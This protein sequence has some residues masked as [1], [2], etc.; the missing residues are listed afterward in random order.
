M[1]II[2]LTEQEVAEDLVVLTKLDYRNGGE[3]SDV[4]QRTHRRC[5][6]PILQNYYY[7]GSLC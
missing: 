4:G 6:A 5:S 2:P 3:Q 7:S 1:A